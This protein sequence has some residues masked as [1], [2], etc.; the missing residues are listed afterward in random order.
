MGQGQSSELDR[1]VQEISRWVAPNEFDEA[2]VRSLDLLV[3]GTLARYF[4]PANERD[5]EGVQRFL[6]NLTPNQLS[7]F[8]RIS[9]KF[10]ELCLAEKD[11]GIWRTKIEQLGVQLDCAPTI[12]RYRTLY[13]VSDKTWYD[14]YTRLERQVTVSFVPKSAFGD[15]SRQYRDWY[16]KDD[17]G[18]LYRVHI[19]ASGMQI[20]TH[21]GSMLS[22]VER[23]DLTRPLLTLTSLKGFWLG[24]PDGQSILVS[25]GQGAYLFVGAKIVLLEMPQDDVVIDFLTLASARKNTIDKQLVVGERRVY[26]SAQQPYELPFEALNVTRADVNR[27]LEQANRSFIAELHEVVLSNA[28]SKPR[29]L[30]SLRTHEVQHSRRAPSGFSSGAQ[31]SWDWRRALRFNCGIRK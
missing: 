14:L 29:N 10:T 21:A 25:L 1:Q 5:R 6:E 8:C 9:P 20:Y 2:A 3:E 24:V 26:I 28:R 15:V 18:Y 4:G 17:L 31:T 30:S 7:N 11:S 23:G 16:I 12:E 27:G 19:N 22:N 13:S